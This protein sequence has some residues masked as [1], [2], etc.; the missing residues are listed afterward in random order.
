MHSHPPPKTAAP[1]ATAAAG[2]AALHQTYNDAET[3]AKCDLGVWKS[4]P[5]RQY[6]SSM[7]EAVGRFFFEFECSTASSAG[8]ELDRAEP[9]R[10]KAHDDE[11]SDGCSSSR[12][13]TPR[14]SPPAGGRVQGPA[15]KR[16]FCHHG[17]QAEALVSCARRSRPGTRTVGESTPRNLWRD[18][19]LRSPTGR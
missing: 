4:G 9:P 16:L 10:E 15:P 12:E 2:A 1:R 8:S 6:D 3:L 19:A 11:R 14:R 17:P 13:S 18:R 7:R 5:S